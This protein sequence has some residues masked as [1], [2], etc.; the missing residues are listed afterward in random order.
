[1]VLVTVRVWTC[2]ANPVVRV[3]SSCYPRLEQRF[4]VLADGNAFVRPSLAGSREVAAN[5]V[6]RGRRS[7]N[8]PLVRLARARESADP[9]RARGASV[10]L[11]LLDPLDLG[12]VGLKAKLVGNRVNLRLE[13]VEAVNHDRI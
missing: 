7:C 5:D 1:M 13:R 4:G 9:V 6:G 2:G 3:G 11:V 8:F 10:R 12:A